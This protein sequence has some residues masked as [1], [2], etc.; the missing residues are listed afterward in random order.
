MTRYMLDTNMVGNLIKSHP[1]VARNVVAVPMGSLC[2][3]SITQGELC[4]GLAKRPDAKSLHRAVREFLLRVDVLPWGADTAERYGTVA[5]ELARQGR[6]L[7]PLDL[8]IAAHALDVDAVLITGDRAFA[9]VAG[10]RVSDW[11]ITAG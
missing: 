9:Q 7:A 8:L 10:L 11:T 3:S 6:I 4:F 5:A 1:V 2:I